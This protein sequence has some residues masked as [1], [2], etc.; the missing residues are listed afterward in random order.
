MTA[1]TQIQEAPC[2]LHKDFSEACNE[3]W[4]ATRQETR[5]H[6][7]EWLRRDQR[8][9]FHAELP[10]VERCTHDCGAPAKHLM[11]EVI[12]PQDPE[13]D[14]RAAKEAWLCCDHFIQVLND[15]FACE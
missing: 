15:S 4:V 3:C 14:T 10:D 12:D 9:Q 13:L 7:A 1:F 5:K 11:R 8:R 6:R 2:A